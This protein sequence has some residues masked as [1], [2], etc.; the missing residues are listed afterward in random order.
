M[1]GAEMFIF[2]ASIPAVWQPTYSYSVVPRTIRSVIM[3]SELEAGQSIAFSAE[4][5]TRTCT[6]APP[7]CFEDVH[8]KSFTFS[9][10]QDECKK[11]SFHFTEYSRR[12]C[13]CSSPYPL[14]KFRQSVGQL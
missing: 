3:Q 1:A 11:I 7:V 10:M 8:I 12:H 6:S 2:T 14:S 13:S 5:N 4:I 9:V